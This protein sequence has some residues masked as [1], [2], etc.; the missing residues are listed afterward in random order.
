[1]LV[2]RTETFAYIVK[3]GGTIITFLKDFK[4]SLS[5]GKVVINYIDIALE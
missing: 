4:S 3:S 2:D 1:M 5:E